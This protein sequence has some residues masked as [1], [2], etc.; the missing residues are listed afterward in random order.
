LNPVLA[1][2]PASPATSALPSVAASG[3]SNPTQSSTA[4]SPAPT[5]KAPAHAHYSHGGSQAVA[6]PTAAGSASI[7]EQLI[8]TYSTTVGGQQFAGTVEESAGVYTVS[9]QNIPYATATGANEMA[10]ENNLN[11]VID[12]LV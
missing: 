5:Q 3:A 6:A 4:Q 9:V 1:A 11:A 12:E 8:G 7:A 10:A 2:K